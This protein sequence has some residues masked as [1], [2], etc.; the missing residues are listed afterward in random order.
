VK[1][2]FARVIS[3]NTS[4]AAKSRGTPL[5]RGHISRTVQ[6]SKYRRISRRISQNSFLGQPGA[7]MGRDSTKK[8]HF[9]PS[10]FYKTR[11]FGKFPTKYGEIWTFS[12]KNSETKYGPF[13]INFWLG[14]TQAA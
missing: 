8:I 14:P 7:G 10:S 4:T 1:P 11:F 3:P 13:E 5:K 6:R 12:R 2:N 9:K